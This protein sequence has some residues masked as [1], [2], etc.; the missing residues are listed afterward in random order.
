M[1][2]RSRRSAVPS[3]DRGT[4]ETLLPLHARPATIR[5]RVINIAV[6]KVHGNTITSFAR[7]HLVGGSLQQILIQAALLL[8]FVWILANWMLPTS[9]THH[10][11]PLPDPATMLNV[12]VYYILNITVYIFP[13]ATAYLHPFGQNSSHSLLAGEELSAICARTNNNPLYDPTLYGLCGLLGRYAFE[14]VSN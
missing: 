6:I 1:V 12:T 7:S 9:R 2:P 14:D 11:F 4:S 5:V 13:S 8:A 10:A 3:R